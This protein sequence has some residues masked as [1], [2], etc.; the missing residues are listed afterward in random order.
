L[1]HEQGVTQQFNELID[2][3]V[4]EKDHATHNQLQGLFI[5]KDKNQ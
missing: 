4:A 3:A 2:V 1:A 5:R